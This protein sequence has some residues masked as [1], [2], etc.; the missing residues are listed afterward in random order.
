MSTDQLPDF[1]TMIECHRYYAKPFS[2]A[3]LF[4]DPGAAQGVDVI[5]CMMVAGAKRCGS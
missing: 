2:A 4:G 1:T 3:V 5:G